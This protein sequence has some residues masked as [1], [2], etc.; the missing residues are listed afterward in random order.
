MDNNELYKMIFSL[1]RRVEELEQRT[2]RGSIVAELI[3]ATEAIRQQNKR[4]SG[5]IEHKSPLRLVKQ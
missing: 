1:A 3:E 2:S 4:L 5:L